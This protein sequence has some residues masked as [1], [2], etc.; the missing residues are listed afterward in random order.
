VAQH[1]TMPQSLSNALDR[2]IASRPDPKPSRPEA[3]RQILAERLT[4][5]A[6]SGD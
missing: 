2:W 1:F 5:A 6:K 3:I 4:P